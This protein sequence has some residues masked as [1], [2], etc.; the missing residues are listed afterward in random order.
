MSG[1]KGETRRGEKKGF[2]R[3]GGKK[4]VELSSLEKGEWPKKKKRGGGDVLPQKREKKKMARRGKKAESDR[5]GKRK[6]C[7]RGKGAF[8]CGRHSGGE[9]FWGRKKRY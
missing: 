7:R 8:A 2:P 4:Q 1:G 3:G 6:R 5:G 9:L